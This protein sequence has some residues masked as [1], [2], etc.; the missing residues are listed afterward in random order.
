[1]GVTAI[2]SA[3]VAAGTTVYAVEEQKKEAKKQRTFTREQTEK[4]ER[5]AN[6]QRQKVEERE[7]TERV[8]EDAMRV[9]SIRRQMQS[10][11]GER[12]TAGVGMNTGSVALGGSSQSRRTAL[13]S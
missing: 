8:N 3:I 5:R 6:K 1:M 11:G 13:G 9:A 10:G 7:Q 2:V 4:A 12:R